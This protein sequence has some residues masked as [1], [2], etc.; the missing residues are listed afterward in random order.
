M[1]G[2]FEKEEEQSA[3]SQ[4][5]GLKKVSSQQSIF[6]TMPK[7]QTPAEFEK[8]V[9][10]VQERASSYKVR[11]AELAL[12]FNKAMADKI[13]PDNRNTFQEEVELDLLRSMVKLAQEINNDDQ[14]NE[15]E[16]SLGWITVLLK[17]C[18]N[19]RDRINNLEYGLFELQK[20]LKPLDTPKKSE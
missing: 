2:A 16:G 4:K 14:E 1:P 10:Q 9:K 7:K 13:L 12:Q 17:T 20:K 3:Q 11:A 6:E 19:Q 15:G 5:I 8:K 18:F